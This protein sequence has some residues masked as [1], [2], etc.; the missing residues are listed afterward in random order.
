MRDIPISPIIKEPLKEQVEISKNNK[1]SLLFTFENRLIKA[2]TINTVLKRICKQLK[3]SNTISNHT[4]RHT[5]GTRCIEAGM[6]PKVI[7]TLMGHKDIAVTL[8]TYTSVLERFKTDEFNK[9]AQYYLNNSANLLPETIFNNEYYV[10][11]D[12][13]EEYKIDNVIDP[14]APY[15]FTDEQIVNLFGSKEAF[16]KEIIDSLK[17]LYKWNKK[18]A[19]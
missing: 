14:Y 6:Q 5:F 1:D 2:S 18:D 19:I 10:V 16:Q 11:D 13:E 7:Q 4:L 17:A 9:V 8:N 15:R 12:T 3:L